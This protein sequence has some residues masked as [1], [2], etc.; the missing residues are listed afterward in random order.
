MEQLLQQG[1]TQMGLPTEGIPSL[2]QY[3]DLLV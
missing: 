2:L 1:L 3:A